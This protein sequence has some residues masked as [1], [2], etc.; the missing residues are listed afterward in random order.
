M[1][2]VIDDYLLVLF[3]FNLSCSV[4]NVWGNCLLKVLFLFLYS[5]IVPYHILTSRLLLQSVSSQGCDS[6]LQPRAT[7]RSSRDP[8]QLHWHV[9]PPARPRIDAFETAT[10]A[11]GHY[12]S[13]GH[14]E[15]LAGNRARSSHSS[16]HLP[17]HHPQFCQPITTVTAS[18]SVTVAVHPAPLASQNPPASYQ[19]YAA[20]DR[21]SSST[22][23]SERADPAF[24][25][26][27]V[28]QDTE[29]GTR[30]VKVEVM[31]LQDLEF[32][33]ADCSSGR[34]AS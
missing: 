17:H 6:G 16:Q 9:P 28:P 32:E 25:D 34:R 21:Y 10:E 30:G 4:G 13:H 15:H 22:P 2:Q 31:E 20:T 7:Q 23:P 26:P 3:C 19:G 11:G 29:T 8:T 14:R 1:R 33:A 24:Q 5:S 12:G 27:H 18:A